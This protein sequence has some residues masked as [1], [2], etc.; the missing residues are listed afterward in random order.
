MFTRTFLLVV[1][2]VEEAECRR[3]YDSATEIYMS[4]FDRTKPPEEVSVYNILVFLRFM[5]SSNSILL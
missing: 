1:Q 2:S 3:A 4:M 5:S